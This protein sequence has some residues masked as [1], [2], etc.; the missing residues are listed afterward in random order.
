MPIGMIQR[1]GLSET[2]AAWIQ[3]Y[4]RD[5]CLKRPVLLTILLFL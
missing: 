5:D 1:E 4:R 2:F 3:A